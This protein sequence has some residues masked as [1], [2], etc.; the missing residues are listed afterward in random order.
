[1]SRPRD[2]NP[3][4]HPGD[5]PSGP[6]PDGHFRAIFDHSA[7]GIVTATLD[8]RLT[9]ANPYFCA[10]LGYRQADILGTSFL[11]LT[12]PGERA[13]NRAQ[14]EALI[15]GEIPDYVTE[16]RYLRRDGTTVHCAVSASLALDPRGRPAQLVALIH[17]L[18]RRELAESRL[19]LAC[20]AARLGA[21]DWDIRTGRV[22]W[23][24]EC[25]DIMGVPEFDGR[26]ETF[27]ALLHP[28]DALWAHETVGQVLAAGGRLDIDLR[29][30]RPDGELR[31]LKSYGRAEY[32]LTGEP[33]R[34]LGTV[35]DITERREM[36]EDLRASERRFQTV[37]DK[38][39]VGIGILRLTD[40]RFLDVNS[41]FAGMS[42][43][44]R[45]ELIGHG[46]EELGLWVDLE[47]QRLRTSR[48]GRV[49][50]AKVR[51]KGGAIRDAM[52]SAGHIVVA[53]DPCLLILAADITARKRAQA[54]TRVLLAAN[55]T[56]SQE[57]IT[58]QERERA[59]LAGELHD[60]LSQALVAIRVYAEAIGRSGAA[61]I[62]R[63]RDHAVAIQD[64]A[65]QI[66]NRSHRLM[67][68]LRP[69]VLDDAGLAEAVSDLVS[70]WVRRHPETRVRLHLPADLGPIDEAARITIYRILQESV[71]NVA[72][73]ARASRLHISLGKQRL[74]AKTSLRL[75]VRDNGNGMNPSAQSAGLGLVLM[76][77]RV[78]GIGG[79]FSV[80]SEAGHGVTI[81]AEV[82]VARGNG[83]P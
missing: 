49:I 36:E 18:T 6:Y 74:D 35:Q 76:R 61:D 62:D 32:D 73:H 80:R 50:E 14:H 15:R 16:Q 58:L 21:W 9:S 70:E 79:R 34:M 47:Q 43:Y 44:A 2:T 3:T 13:A 78:E 52:M 46:P 7:A 38:S 65:L 25:H 68:G 53:A 83:T 19:R 37:F 40:D 23:S 22:Y 28:D 69:Q 8:G 45:D 24:P 29:I 4:G 64:S 27:T 82:P 77:E 12:H 11:D 81:C 1:M 63:I 41:A 30:I 71:A 26:V 54:K 67:E 31:W 56:L 51:R 57:L 48:G 17:D 60:E 33:V 59:E 5:H 39:P 42:G 55:R 75:V 66:Y 72:K 10:L 20:A